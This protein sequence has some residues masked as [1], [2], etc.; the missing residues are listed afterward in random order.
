M[1]PGSQH[2]GNSKGFRNLMPEA[3][4]KT[5]YIFLPVNLDIT[6]IVLC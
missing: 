1:F 4:T 6:G 3:K 5:K 2:L